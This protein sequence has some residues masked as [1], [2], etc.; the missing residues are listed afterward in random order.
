MKQKKPGKAVPP[1]ALKLG[2]LPTR[3]KSDHTE[4]TK[5]TPPGGGGD[6]RDFKGLRKNLLNLDLSRL[7]SQS[8][9]AL[10]ISHKIDQDMQDSARVK[11][12]SFVIDD[13]HVSEDIEGEA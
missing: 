2:G 5:L 7:S 12:K 13:S 6:K 11:E 3:D 8:S 1:L 9:G 4:E 10:N